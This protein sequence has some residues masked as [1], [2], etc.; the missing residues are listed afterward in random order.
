MKRP[1]RSFKSRIFESLCAARPCVTRPCQHTLPISIRNAA[2]M[3][4]FTASAAPG[5]ALRPDVP[6]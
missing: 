6:E 3:F 5:V 2:P 4:L 1:W